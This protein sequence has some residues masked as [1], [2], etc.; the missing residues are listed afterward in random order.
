MNDQKHVKDKRDGSITRLGVNKTVG[1]HRF[2][3][4]NE[5]I[6][7]GAPPPPVVTRHIR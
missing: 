2:M 3:G 5:N 4:D 6:T 1:E 7:N